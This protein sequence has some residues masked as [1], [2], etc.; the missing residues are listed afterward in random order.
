MIYA[1]YLTYHQVRYHG[2]QTLEKKN[3]NKLWIFFNSRSFSIILPTPRSKSLMLYHNNKKNI[4]CQPTLV[5]HDSVDH[6]T[7]TSD[8][9]TV[10]TNDKK[11][12]NFDFFAKCL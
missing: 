11:N 1:C 10:L 4:L 2:R 7:E 6:H 3:F 12:Q 9:T 8:Y 5:H